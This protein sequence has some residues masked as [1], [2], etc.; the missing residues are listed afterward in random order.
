MDFYD[1]GGT[2][3]F[4]ILSIFIFVVCLEKICWTVD[5]GGKLKDYFSN[6]PFRTIT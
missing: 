2:S 4:I 3:L 6:F 1:S 5:R